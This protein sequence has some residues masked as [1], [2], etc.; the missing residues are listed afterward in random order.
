MNKLKSFVLFFVIF[1]FPLFVLG[2]TKFEKE[3]RIKPEEVPS[4]ALQFLHSSNTNFSEKWYY[5]KNLV[6]NSVEAKFK[7]NKAHYSVE[8]DTLGNIQD[9]EVETEFHELPE[10][11][12]SEITA[13]LQNSYSKFKITRLQIQYSRPIESFQYF[14]DNKDLLN[15]FPVNYELIVKGKSNNQLELYEITFNPNGEMVKTE[16]IIFR[17]T[18]NLEF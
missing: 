10:K 5:E 4:K 7:Y 16:Q 17:N 1:S 14:L 9:I 3:H 12:Q 2:Q 13:S 8:F 15:K 6:G 18:D 11:L